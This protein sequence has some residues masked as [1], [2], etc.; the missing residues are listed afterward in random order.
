MIG[1]YIFAHCTWFYLC[2]GVMRSTRV[3]AHLL[4]W[5]IVKDLKFSRAC[6]P[7]S[8]FLLNIAIFVYFIVSPMSYIDGRHFQ[9]I[10]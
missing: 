9:F 4:T 7:Y 2:A 3:C 1:G 10:T 8:F 6:P 5:V